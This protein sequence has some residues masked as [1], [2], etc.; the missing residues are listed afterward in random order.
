MGY[1]DESIGYQKTDTSKSAAN[2]NKKGKVSIR[3]Q[4]RELF[5][6]NNLLTVEDVSRLLNR[7]EISVQ[8]RVSELKNEG[9]LEDSGIRRQGKWGTNV[10]VWRCTDYRM[11]LP[12]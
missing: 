9:I 5:K 3:Q 10:I 11:E 1:N 2:F 12:K 4:V 8:P 6:E 7:P